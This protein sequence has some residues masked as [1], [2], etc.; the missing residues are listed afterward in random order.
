[1]LGQLSYRFAG[2][3]DAIPAATLLQALDTYYHPDKP[4]PSVATY[5]EMVT[6]TLSTAEGTRFAL[7]FSGEQ[8]VGIA[9][10]A[11]LRPGNSLKGL[12]FL[13]DL[14]VME[15]ARGAGV[16]RGLMG[17]LS[18]F[19]LAEGIGR[20]DLQT[21]TDNEGARKLYEA[22]GGT[23]REKVAYSFGAE[24]MSDL[25]ERSQLAD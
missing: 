2:V 24:A 1:M 19:A 5:G 16:G 8:P 18:R 7:A 17:F 14:F 12:I 22:L 15:A 10:I 13:K 21:D 6:R 23:R 9:C 3:A 11:V 4:H 25:S 20:I